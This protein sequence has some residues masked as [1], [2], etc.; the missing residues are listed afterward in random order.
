MLAV[1]SKVNALVKSSGKRMSKDAWQALDARIRVIVEGAIKATGSFKTI[2]ETEI[3]M[4]GRGM[5]I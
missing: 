4:S 3:L 2:K 5:S 1:K